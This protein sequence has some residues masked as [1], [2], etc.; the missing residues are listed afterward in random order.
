M[1]WRHG[2]DADG[3]WSCGFGRSVPLRRVVARGGVGGQRVGG[4][5][6][7]SAI[8]RDGLGR[9]RAAELRRVG[10]RRELPVRRARVGERGG[11][12]A[13]SC[14]GRDSSDGAGLSLQGDDDACVPLRSRE[15]RVGGGYHFFSWPDLFLSPSIIPPPLLPREFASM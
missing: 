9:S 13:G 12:S 6:R 3:H 14:G 5:V 4:S 1:E 10:G 15:R 2:G 11:A 7:V 8:G